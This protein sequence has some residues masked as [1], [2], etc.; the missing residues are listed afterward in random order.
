MAEAIRAA[1]LSVWHGAR[2]AVEQVSLHA[3]YGELLAVTG[4]NAAGKSS[5]VKALLGLLPYRGEIWVAGQPLSAIHPRERARTIAY[6][7]QRSAVM[8]QVSVMDV[9]AQARYAHRRGFGRSREED[10]VIVQALEDTEL[11]AL[12]H[13]T[14][15]T[16]SGGEQRRVLMA[17]ALATGARIMVLDEPTAGLDIGAVLRFFKL[18]QRLKS[19]G[20][21]LICV[22]H[23]LGD[24]RRHADAALLLA[25]GRPQAFG[26]TAKV[27]SA[28][29]VQQVYGVHLHERV[30]LGF[31]LTGE[32]P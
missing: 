3:S 25:Q 11:S 17:R 20:H 18:A 2:L 9:V 22:L 26:V 12:G 27:L 19:D 29:N 15:H 32:A 6:V 13:R 10:A 5:L 1:G 21:A 16:L 23:D 24:V 31:S 7:P 4:P 14:F 8:P 28:A 30:G